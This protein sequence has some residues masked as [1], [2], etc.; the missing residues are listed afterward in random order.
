[1]LIRNIVSETS[2]FPTVYTMSLNMLS[3]EKE[4]EKYWQG[5]R[6]GDREDKRE[7]KKPVYKLV[8]RCSSIKRKANENVSAPV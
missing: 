2:H 3:L 1:M 7:R 5:K 4:R 6:E 8:C